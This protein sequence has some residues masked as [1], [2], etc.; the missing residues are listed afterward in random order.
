[1]KATIARAVRWGVG[2]AVLAASALPASAQLKLSGNLIVRVENLRNTNGSV[3]IALFE[4]SEGFPGDREEAKEG[5]CKEIE[6]DTVFFIF[7]DLQS[8][9]YAIAAFHDENG[10]EELDRNP[11]G[12]PREGFGF[13]QNPDTATRVPDYEEAAIFLVGNTQVEVEMRYV[14]I[15]L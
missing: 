15:D 2:V 12:I 4:G 14:D 8:G 10:D 1:M 6:R 13:S 7:Q 9:T 3:C 11:I 5:Q